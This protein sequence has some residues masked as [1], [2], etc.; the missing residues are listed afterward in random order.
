MSA[1]LVRTLHSRSTATAQVLFTE[2]DLSTGCKR[3]IPVC[4]YFQAAWS[5][6]SNASWLVLISDLSFGDIR[7]QET[8]LELFSIFCIDSIWSVV[9]SQVTRRCPICRVPFAAVLRLLPSN[10]DSN[11]TAEESAVGEEGCEEE[12]SVVVVHYSEGQGPLQRR[13]PRAA[14]VVPP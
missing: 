14:I 10:C 7:S 4:V 2:I 6:C 9:C 8:K 3:H 5:K 12:I 1:I 11:H 13:P